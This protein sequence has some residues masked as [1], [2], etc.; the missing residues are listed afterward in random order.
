MSMEPT[1]EWNIERRNTIWKELYVFIVIS[2][3]VQNL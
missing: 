3:N 2:R 1:V